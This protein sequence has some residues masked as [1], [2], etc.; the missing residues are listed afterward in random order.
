MRAAAL[1]FLGSTLLLCAG[2]AFVG[3]KGAGSGPAARTEIGASTR[4]V[5]HDLTRVSVRGSGGGGGGGVGGEGEGVLVVHVSL[6]DAERP[7][8]SVRPLGVFRVRLYR[9]RDP[10]GEPRA[11]QA[12]DRTWE[13]DLRSPK[14]NAAAFDEFISRTYVL[15]L[16]D[17]PDWLR[18]WARG[19]GP[20][21]E[22]PS[23]VV[24]F[25]P[26]EAVG[27]DGA[28]TLRAGASLSR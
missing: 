5:V 12:L 8:E 11:T 19:E 1:A 26:S 25:T 21:G 27:G 18:R 2:G 20:A 7:D 3:C 23:V 10:A 16:P 22:K 6:F 9:P 15:E 17:A 4:M 13:V 28:S 14:R 24:E